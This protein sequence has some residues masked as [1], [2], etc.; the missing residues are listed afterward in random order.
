MEFGTF[1]LNE[2]DNKFD[3]RGSN[4]TEGFLVAS[5]IAAIV[6][7]DL[8]QH[9][10]SYSIDDLRLFAI[11]LKNHLESP[12]EITATAYKEAPYE[13]YIDK[14]PIREIYIRPEEV[15]GLVRREKTAGVNPKI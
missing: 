1:K 13:F 3:I 4:A 14:K 9:T 6:L 15:V 7:K 8:D 10:P 12:I 2:E 5:E 11:Y